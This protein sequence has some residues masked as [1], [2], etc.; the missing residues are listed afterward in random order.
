MNPSDLP[1]QP[2]HLPPAPGWWPPAPGWWLLMALLLVLLAGSGYWWRQR[3]RRLARLAW[4]NETLAR[5][6][7]DPAGVLSLHR[8]LRRALQPLAGTSALEA[9]R[10]PA[11][12]AQLAGETRIEALLAQEAQCYQP[13][14]KLDTQAVAEARI[15][16]ELVLLQPRRARKRLAELHP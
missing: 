1:L 3:Q 6:R 12:L 13:Q 7:Q 4:L 14:A 2:L 16:L 8:L 15:L 11:L 9:E 10:W 5:L